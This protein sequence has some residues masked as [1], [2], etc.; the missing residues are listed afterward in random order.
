MGVLKIM[1]IIAIVGV[2]AFAVTN[3]FRGVSWAD[4]RDNFVSDVLVLSGL[5]L[6]DTYE[7][8]SVVADRVVGGFVELLGTNSVRLPINEPTVSTFWN[9]YTGAIDAALRKGRVVL[10]YW[11]PSQ[12][13]GP[14]NMDDFWA[15]WTKV[16]KTYGD[17]L[18]LISRSSTSLTCIKPMSSAIF[19]R[20]GFRSFRTS[21]GI[22]SSWTAPALHGMFL[23]L[24]AIAAST[25]AFSPF[26]IIPSGRT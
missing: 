4:R 11:G 2:N 10:G 23:I 14:K 19:M 8:A 12:P 20:H 18:T 24:P 9:T 5:S 17:N 13:S 15:M 1:S 21:P 22:V 6:T 7:S 25:G 16:V 3:Q 26:T